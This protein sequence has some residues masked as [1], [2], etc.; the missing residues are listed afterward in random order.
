M[1]CRECSNELK[2]S[3]KF[4]TKCGTK[5]TE[6]LSNPIAHPES[7]YLNWSLQTGIGEICRRI[8]LVEIRRHD[9]AKGIIVGMGTKA[10]FFTLN[11][12]NNVFELSS[13]TYKFSDESERKKRQ[14]AI[15]KVESQ[16][17]LAEQRVENSKKAENEIGF[18]KKIALWFSGKSKQDEKKEAFKENA[19]KKTAKKEEDLIKKKKA[20]S[21][22]QEINNDPFMIYLMQE[23]NIVLDFD[24]KNIPVKDFQTDI[25]MSLSITISDPLMFIGDYMV[26]SFDGMTSESLSKRLKSHI[27]STLVNIV[28][29]VDI[30]SISYNDELKSNLIEAI[31][32][33][34]EELHSSIEVVD[35]PKLTYDNEEISQLISER[36]ENYILQKQLEQKIARNQITNLY[37]T[38][39]N[40]QEIEADLLDIQKESGMWS[41]EK[42]RLLLEDEKKRFS[43]LLEK[44]ELLLNAK[45][46]DEIKTAKAELVKTGLLREQDVNALERRIREEN[47]DHQVIRDHSMN[48]IQLNQLIERESLELNHDIDKRRTE[49]ETE[50]GLSDLQIEI[51]RKKSD[52]LRET[53]RKDVEDEIDEQQ[54]RMKLAE[55]AQAL[56][57]KK[58]KAEHDREIQ[59]K[60]VDS[61]LEI[62]KLKVQ[63]GMTAEQIMVSNPN[64]SPDVAKAMAEK[65][66]AEAAEKAN[67]KR[68]E[69]ALSQADKMKDFIEGQN[70][71][72]VDIV[73]SV[74]GMK[75]ETEPQKTDGLKPNHAFCHSCGE[76]V[77]KEFKFCP[78]CRAEM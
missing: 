28:R 52:A 23:K 53:R 5:V 6:V 36:S 17:K 3:A 76:Q 64:I 7:G 47:E 14:D 62:D 13:N 19:R 56:T 54:K 72:L 39:D 32:L 37:L 67:D 18:W 11:G 55:D 46:E 42:N 60:K 45:T 20:L 1:N 10:V 29:S 25:W 74:T 68:A 26:D 61:Q 31:S 24:F 22:L 38:T 63:G 43:L 40:K 44:E 34:L 57:E 35:I 71:N 66:K 21:K 16:I 75:S 49:L 69:D 12:E 8:S 65:F 73:K 27:E 30:E 58:R 78:H 70:K 2:P 15:T 59:A 33:K 48:I 41:N 4:C 51:D 77:S 50:L 9:N